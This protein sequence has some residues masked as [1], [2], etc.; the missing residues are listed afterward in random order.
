MTGFK[1][2]IGACV[3]MLWGSLLFAAD[4]CEKIAGPLLKAGEPSAT[5]AYLL[6]ARRCFGE[7]D[8]ADPDVMKFNALLK[9]DE[10]VQARVERALKMVESTWL[11][12]ASTLQ[13]EQALEVARKQVRE[14]IRSVESVVAPGNE[15]VA[16]VN[17]EWSLAS[18]LPRVSELKLDDTLR[19]RC[20]SAQAGVECE[21]AKRS[22]GQWLRLSNLMRRGLVLYQQEYMDSVKAY[23]D[24]RVRS[25]HAY[26]DDGLPQYPWEYWL[27]SLMMKRNDQR[28]RV[29]NN[30][31]GYEKIPTSQLIFMHP[32]ASLEWREKRGQS[33]EENL[34]PALYVEVFGINRWEY[35]ATGAMLGGKGVSLMVSYTNREGREST[36]YGL[37]F[38][39]RKTKQFSLGIARAG[40]DTVY[41][42]NVDL[43]EYFKTQLPYWADVQTKIDGAQ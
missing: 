15:P 33:G 2:V 30:P 27:N 38:H 12:P 21:Q 22:A 34:K 26:R 41:L 25:W 13:P 9:G 23:A 19:S 43:A 35:D 11:G 37:M 36:G 29:N 8:D 32:G 5:Q 20:A 3:L 31:V 40:G 10:P 14:T 42:L 18:G 24:T 7:T 28:P 16:P 1:R 39:S 17:W 4:D 6:T